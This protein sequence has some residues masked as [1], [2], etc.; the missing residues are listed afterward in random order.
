[1]GAPAARP[2]LGETAPPPWER[3]PPALGSPPEQRRSPGS[4]AAT[5]PRA[6]ASPDPRLAMLP[7]RVGSPDPLVALPDRRVELNPVC[8]PHKPQIRSIEPPQVRED[9]AEIGRSHAEPAG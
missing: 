5:P 9:R 2:G 4:A 1:M 7:R 3:S 6:P 8:L